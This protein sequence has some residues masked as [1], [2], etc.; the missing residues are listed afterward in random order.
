MTVQDNVTLA[1]GHQPDVATLADACYL[2]R[3][4]GRVLKNQVSDEVIRI[5]S[6]PGG[7]EFSDIQPLVAGARGRVRGPPAGVPAHGQQGAGVIR[8]P[9]FFATSAGGRNR[10]S[11]KRR[12]WG[13]YNCF[14][15]VFTGERAARPATG[16]V[17][18]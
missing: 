13:E 6:R 14:R 8:E 3:N 18:H 11:L 17:R 2:M 16:T 9:P 12:N 4:T 5:E 15:G 7:C 1:A 10:R